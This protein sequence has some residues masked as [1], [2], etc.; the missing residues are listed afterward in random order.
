MNNLMMIRRSRPHEWTPDPIFWLEMHGSKP[1]TAKTGQAMT[2][3][4]SITT[5]TIGGKT[6]NRMADTT[7]SRIS[8]A[9]SLSSIF[10]STVC[11]WCYFSASGG[12]ILTCMGGNNG[13]SNI[14][15]YRAKNTNQ[16]LYT[17]N[18]QYGYIIGNSGWHMKAATLE[19]DGDKVVSKYYNDGILQTTMTVAKFGYTVVV[20]K[21][22]IGNQMQGTLYNGTNGA[23]Y[24]DC[25]LFNY[26][27]T[28]EQIKKI[29]D[30]QKDLT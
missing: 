1:A 30:T 11:M 27:L 9:L 18:I 10:P 4:G 29:Y 15:F 3:T 13:T 5:G 12:R 28:D 7:G 24:R 20:D 2:Y 6:Y 16:A 25:M 19:L 17:S 26:V 14:S 21:F 22:S 8:C 23:Y